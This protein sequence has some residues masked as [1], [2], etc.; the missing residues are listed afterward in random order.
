MSVFYRINALTVLLA[1]VVITV[2]A[3]VR[4]SDAGLGCPDWP[5]CYGH[6]D[7]PESQAETAVANAAF[8]E[9]PVEA[10]KAWKEMVHR[11]LAGALGL[12]I[13]TMAVLAWRRW[14]VIGQQRVLP[15]VLL[16]VVVFQALLG[17]WTVTLLLKPLI[18]AAHLLGGMATLALLWLCLLRQGSHLRGMAGVSG[19]RVIATIALAVLL[20]QLFLGAWTSSNYA[21]LACP[22]FPT[23]QAR[24]WPETDFARAFKLWHGLGINYEYGILDSVPRATIHWTHRIGALIT[25][26]VMMLVAARLWLLGGGD[27]RWRRLAVA[28]V[29]VTMLQIGLGIATV[30][31][32]LPLSVAVAHNGGAA[33]LLLTVMTICHAAW[34]VDNDARE[35]HP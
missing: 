32:H 7:V 5:G 24:W 31:L 11:Y 4:L 35:R 34:S 25:T 23:C 18:V 14:H 28:L 2:G 20:A 12:L 33:L 21:A 16:G 1:F 9:R 6:L 8:P 3:F 29:A 15:V 27:Q 30:V 19:L 13:L 22:D 17:M 26:V 10:G